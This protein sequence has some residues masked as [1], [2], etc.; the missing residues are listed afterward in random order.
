VVVR[1]GSTPFQPF[2]NRTRAKVVARCGF[3]SFQAFF[4][5]H[6]DEGGAAY[7]EKGNSSTQSAQ[8]NCNIFEKKVEVIER[9]KS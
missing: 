6:R 2:V 3:T 9:R 8:Q 7:R 4:N 1:G 5:C